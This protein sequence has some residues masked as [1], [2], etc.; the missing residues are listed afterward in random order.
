[1]TK[2]HNW[3]CI[4]SIELFRTK[5][6]VMKAGSLWN[7][8]DVL[9]KYKPWVLEI[10]ATFGEMKTASICFRKNVL[11]MHHLYACIHIFHTK[12][13]IVNDACRNL[14]F[15]WWLICW[16]SHFWYQN[17]FFH[18]RA[19]HCISVILYLIAHQCM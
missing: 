13:C 4:L 14:G 1:M 8:L 9:L 19:T 16:W 12:W 3:I 7:P 18:T 15:S 6:K 5:Y 11:L 10:I 17:P 2:R